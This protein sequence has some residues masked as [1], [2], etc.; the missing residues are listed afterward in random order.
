MYLKLRL[1]VL[2]DENRKESRFPCIIS[3]LVVLH[4]KCEK[5]LKADTTT[6][7]KHGTPT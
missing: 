7:F 6:P 5:K 3:K 1:V 2:V 4:L